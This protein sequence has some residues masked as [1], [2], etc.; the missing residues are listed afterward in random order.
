MKQNDEKPV[1]NIVRD[2][3]ELANIDPLYFVLTEKGKRDGKWV[4]EDFFATGETRITTV[5][6]NAKKYQRPSSHGK[7]LDFGCGAGRL[8]RALAKHFTHCWG[9]DASERMIQLAKQLNNSFPNCEFLV[10][11]SG[12]LPMFPDDMFDMVW[13]ELVLQH[14]PTRG[15]IRSYIQE[16]VRTLTKD[17][18]LVFQI[19]SK[20][21]LRYLIQPRRRLYV[22]LK[23][24]GFEGSLL[25][26]KMRLSP[27]RMTSLP[28]RDVLSTLK[29]AGATVLDAKSENLAGEGIL[30]RTYYVTK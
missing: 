24:L 3:D 15:L 21:S 9:L 22:F 1:S 25:Y 11:R 19:P 10:N 5:L 17:G 16:F 13:S 26:E 23:N 7:A 29:G 27:M 2:W 30:S 6:D 28:E 12:K 8:T 20:I 14:L 18:L 4:P